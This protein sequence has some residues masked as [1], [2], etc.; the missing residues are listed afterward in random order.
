MR[1]PENSEPSPPS[2]QTSLLCMTIVSGAI[3]PCTVIVHVSSHQYK[4][5][6]TAGG[7]GGNGGGVDE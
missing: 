1:Q 5:G 4:G 7:L 3:S 2:L 6:G